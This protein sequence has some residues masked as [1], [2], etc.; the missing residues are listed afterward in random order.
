MQRTHSARARTTTR[1][2]QASLQ[3]AANLWS[4]PSPT[5]TTF[6]ETS[7]RA[8]RC[9]LAFVALIVLSLAT[10]RVV[11]YDRSDAQLI[12]V[13]FVVGGTLAALADLVYLG[14][15]EYWHETGWI[16]QPPVKDGRRWES[17]GVVAPS[18]AGLRRQVS[19]SWRPAWCARG[20]LRRTRAEVPFRLGAS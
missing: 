18:P 20:R 19:S 17:I 8:T 14:G 11:G 7:S 15:T 1:L 5:S 4:V 10:R 3:D 6:C 12:T 2:E 9:S 13:L 16:A